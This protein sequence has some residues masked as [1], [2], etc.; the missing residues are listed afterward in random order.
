MNNLEYEN[1]LKQKKTQQN[2]KKVNPKK[3]FGLY[4][5][6]EE[7]QKLDKYKLNAA[8]LEKI[9]E[10]SDEENDKN[11]E[12]EKRKGSDKKIKTAMDL[13]LSLDNFDKFKF[14]SKKKYISI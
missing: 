11:D 7:R 8:S 9:I 6:T 5:T 10:G 2:N 3:R 13:G 1:Y 4:N 12:I 14:S